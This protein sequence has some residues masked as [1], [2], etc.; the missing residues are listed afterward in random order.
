MQDYGKI[1][2]LGSWED[3]MKRGEARGSAL[4]FA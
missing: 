3:L 1:E 4:R 2:G